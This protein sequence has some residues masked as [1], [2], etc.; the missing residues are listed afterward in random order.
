MSFFK[1]KL[2]CKVQSLTGTASNKMLYNF[3]KRWRERI[4][5]HAGKKEKWSVMLHTA[6]RKVVE[7]HTR[8]GGCELLNFLERGGC[9]CS[10]DCATKKHRYMEE[11]WLGRLFGAWLGARTERKRETVETGKRG[12]DFFLPGG[13]RFWEKYFYVKKIRIRFVDVVVR[14]FCWL[15]LAIS[16]KIKD[17]VYAC[18][19]FAK[20]R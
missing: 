5:V 13:H 10:Q 14:T 12:K 11:R 9:C 17:F 15:K 1:K 2:V 7:R 16:P 8:Y 20:S 6:C 3:G 19:F 18:R 4:I